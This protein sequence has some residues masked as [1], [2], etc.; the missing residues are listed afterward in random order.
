MLCSM[1]IVLVAVMVFF[2][3]AGCSTRKD[4]F[5]NRAY[6]QTT[7]QYNVLFNGNEALNQGIE[8]QTEAHQ[9][10]FW[11]RL[12]L[13]P[14]SLPDIYETDAPPNPNYTRAETKAVAAVQKHSMRIGGTQR[15]KQI[16]EAY[17]LLG[18]ARFYNGRYLQ[19]IEAFN[20]IIDQLGDSNSI[21]AAQLWRAKTFL[22]LNQEERAAK[23]LKN[24]IDNGALSMADTAT[25]YAAYAQALLALDNA[26]EAT[27]PLQKALQLEKDKNLVARYAYVLGQLYDALGHS[28]SATVAYQNVIDLNRKIPRTYWIHA[29]LNQL[30]AGLLPETQTKTA[31]KRLTNNDENKKFLDKIHYSHAVFHMGLGDTLSTESL[32]NKSLRTGTQDNDLKGMVYETLADMHFDRA[33]FLDSGAYLDST[34]SVTDAKSRKFRK[35]KR[36]RD[37]L[38]DIISYEN[39]I[40]VHDSI[41]GLMDK[42]PEERTQF[43]ADYIAQ[44]KRKDSIQKAQE[45]QELA[46]NVSFFGNDFYFYNR[47]QLARGKSDFLRIWGDIALE[48]NWRY[49]KPKPI[50]TPAERML[51]DTLSTEKTIEEP[52]YLVETY[53]VQIPEEK[54]R[55]SLEQVRNTALFQAGLAYKEQFLVFDLAKERLQRLLSRPSDYTLP[56][57]YHLYQIEQQTG[58]EKTSHYKSR[59]LAEF[60]DSQYAK[61]IVNPTQVLEGE[62]EAHYEEVKQMFATQKFESVIDK[63]A[64]AILGV[65]DQDLRARFALLRAEALGRLDGIEIYKA[66]LK[67]VSTTYPKQAAGIDANARLRAIE[68]ITKSSSAT[69]GYKLLFVTNRDQHEQTKVLAQAC[70]DWIQTQSLNLVLSVSVDVYNRDSE[71]LVV[72]GFTDASSAKDFNDQIQKELKELQT[73][74]NFVVLTSQFRDA[75]IFKDLAVTLP[76]K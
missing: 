31:Y 34:M 67:E 71:L 74:K 52:R 7:T 68:Q 36:K 27:T 25:A 40:Q 48:D 59:L 66:A 30:N 75:L 72:H 16:D 15:N 14:F 65:Q 21:H 51:A 49:A 6:H 5:V 70:T 45:Q 60:P 43:F 26:K 39:D 47:T 64:Q 13:D 4:G 69:G 54:A 42:S 18:K 33:L 62:F 22:Q 50:I 24:L 1:R 3:L 55:D 61:I 46:A 32:M 41:L 28:D 10:N 56:T 2:V 53:L 12:P 44:I 63:A 9:P 38:K 11:T 17:M 58:G 20:Y 35:V 29:T 37:K 23:E 8:A 73:L 19:A 57:L 76:K